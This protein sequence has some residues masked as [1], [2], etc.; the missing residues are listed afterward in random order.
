[1][2]YHK[3]QR[4]HRTVLY[5][6]PA[7]AQKQNQ[8]TLNTPNGIPDLNTQMSGWTT[9]NPA[10]K[11]PRNAMQNHMRRRRKSSQGDGFSNSRIDL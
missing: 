10:G 1:M 6:K 7:T 3:P 2:K 5:R 9:K 11:K 8:D 4:G